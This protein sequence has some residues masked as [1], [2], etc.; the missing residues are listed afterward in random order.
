MKDRA[1]QRNPV[2]K[3]QKKKKKKKRIM[4]SVESST[5][6]KIAR[7][8]PFRLLLLIWSFSVTW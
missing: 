8:I 2:F 7:Y 4:K 5:E 6:N 1:T 3:S